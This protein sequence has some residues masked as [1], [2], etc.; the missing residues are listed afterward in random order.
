MLALVAYRWVVG[1]TEHREPAE[2]GRGGAA[3]SVGAGLLIGV[4]L[5]AVVIGAITVLG[6][7]RID[8]WGSVTGA[9][10]LLGLAVA[11]GTTEELLFRG[12]LFRIVERRTGTWIALL[13]TAVLFGGMHLLNPEASAGSARSCSIPA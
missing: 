10:G 7:Y 6:G 2:V 3:R 5:F 8:G 1:R 4:G 12:V 9:A 13:L 11:A